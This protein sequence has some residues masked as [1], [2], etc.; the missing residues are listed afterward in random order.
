MGAIDQLIYALEE[1][2]TDDMGSSVEEDSYQKKDTG[3]FCVCQCPIRR[4]VGEKTT[5]QCH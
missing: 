5:S 1:P 4:A 3:K 2:T